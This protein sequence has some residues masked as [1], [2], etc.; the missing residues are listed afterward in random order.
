MSAQVA[1]LIA[2]KVVSKKCENHT[3]MFEGLEDC[4]IGILADFFIQ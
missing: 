2:D 4:S 1:S 3:F